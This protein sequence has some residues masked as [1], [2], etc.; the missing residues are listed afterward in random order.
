[1]TRNLANQENSRNMAKWSIKES[2]VINAKSVT[3]NL[4]IQET[5]RDMFK[6][7]MTNSNHSLVYN[8]R[9]VSVYKE[10]KRLLCDVGEITGFVIVLTLH[11]GSHDTTGKGR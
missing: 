4:A 11:F 5:S 3:R 8:V 2:N 6:Q 7:F 1:M 10:V 9:K